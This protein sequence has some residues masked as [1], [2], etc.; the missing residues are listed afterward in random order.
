MDGGGRECPP[1]RVGAPFVPLPPPV[2]C[3]RT[4]ADAYKESRNAFLEG[5]IAGGVD[6]CARLQEHEARENDS[7]DHRD[8]HTPS[9]T[10]KAGVN[11]L[12]ATSNALRCRQK[13]LFA[14]HGASGQG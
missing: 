5:L 13:F 12:S 7:D 4:D 8:G 9:F 6:L 11:L 14:T 10:S 2:R 3:R 1:T